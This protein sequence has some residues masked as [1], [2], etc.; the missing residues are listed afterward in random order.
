MPSCSGRE[1][2]NSL[3]E[4]WRMKCF[5]QRATT[6]K[7]LVFSQKKGGSS[8]APVPDNASAYRPARRQQPCKSP[9]PEIS[10][11]KRREKTPIHQSAH[12]AHSFSPP[13]PAALWVANESR[14]QSAGSNTLIGRTSGLAGVSEGTRQTPSRSS[15][16]DGHPIGRVPSTR[17]ASKT[18]FSTCSRRN[19]TGRHTIFWRSTA[20]PASPGCQGARAGKVKR[21]VSVCVCV[22]LCV[23]SNYGLG[24]RQKHAGM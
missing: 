8:K 15:P 22:R 5:L 3:G 18:F 19:E 1:N 2:G 20:S 10:E 14:S 24:N 4:I 23:M 16:P 17:L 9:N 13:G 6:P 21:G 11:G 12:T 7:S